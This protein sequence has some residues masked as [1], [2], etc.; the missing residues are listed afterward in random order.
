M[1]GVS[2]RF[3][4][5]HTV[6]GS[7]TLL[8]LSDSHGNIPALEAV[9]RWTKGLEGGAI[10]AA[11]FLGDGIRDLSRASAAA[12]FACE[13]KIVRGNNDDTFSVPDT[14]VLGFGGH[15]FFLCHGHR[16][17]LYGGYHSLIA[18]ARNLEADTVLF[19]HTHAPHYE[20]FGG[21][22]LINP[23]SIGRPRGRV[24]ATFAIVECVSKEPFDVQFWG[25]GR[26]GK[27]QEVRVNQN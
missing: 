9:F 3:F 6:M 15:R 23:G 22:T 24:G 25:I 12:G 13:W 18:A 10:G 8:V 1:P 19:G 7:K 26:E 20:N 14:A 2:F 5:Y 21:V 4:Y 17:S 27:I 16:H 11:V